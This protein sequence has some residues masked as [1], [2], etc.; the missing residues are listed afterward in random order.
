[1][2]DAEMTRWLESG[3]LLAYLDGT[4]DAA[5]QADL[6]RALTASPALRQ[7]LAAL[8]Q[9]Q[10]TLDER[11]APGDLPAVQT[12]GDYVLGLLPP[13]EAAAVAAQLADHPHAA[14]QA[15]ALAAYLHDLDL[16]PVP[17]RE[18]RGRPARL[19]EQ[20]TTLIA[21]LVEGLG[22]GPMPALAGVRGERE[23]A[24]RARRVY[25]ADDLQLMLEIQPSPE[26]PDRRD[27]LGLVTGPPVPA[28]YT[29]DLVQ[30]GQPVATATVD[31]LGNFVL[32]A[33]AAG[34]YAL[35]LRRADQEIAIPF[36]P[37]E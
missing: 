2:N 23:P 29:V 11:L 34:D 28:A 10:R 18:T 20:V 15:A 25:A 37:V 33:V 17:A 8:A 22:G 14:Q 36:L 27:I 12:L 1:M 31:R 4:L 35:L 9:L 7:E 6:E 5:T 13:A 16:P 26:Q 32:A 3:A 24:G 19:V 21:Q 30:A